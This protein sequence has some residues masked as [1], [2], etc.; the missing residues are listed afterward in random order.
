MKGKNVPVIYVD[1]RDAKTAKIELESV[2]RIERSLR[3]VPCDHNEQ[4]IAIPL[5]EDA[6]DEELSLSVTIQA[7][8][9]HDCPCS[10]RVYASND[11]S[12]R[13]L[14]PL[15]AAIVEQTLQQTSDD[16]T[17]AATDYIM[18]ESIISKLQC[19]GEDCCPN[20]LEVLGLDRTIVIPL[21]ALRP[22]DL[23]E[24]HDCWKHES[25]YDRLWKSLAKQMDSHRVIRRGEID[26]ESPIRQSQ[27]QLL[28]YDESFFKDQEEAHWI[29]VKEDGILQT[30][31]IERLMF[32]RGNITEKMRFGRKLV[33]PGERVLDLYAGIGYFSLPAAVHGKAQHV[34]CCEWNPHAGTCSIYFL[35]HTIVS[36]IFP[37]LT[38]H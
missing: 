5:T 25:S 33:Q 8:G 11:E 16:T 27:Y 18:E 17:T 2:H 10:T 9:R 30:F 3:M 28:W 14:S 29:T 38:I 13:R 12:G 4:W 6:D 23:G 19:F 31:H 22:G 7:H 36:C 26:P 15:I 37:L 32:S 35:H 1:K 34:T 20:K 21:N 24:I